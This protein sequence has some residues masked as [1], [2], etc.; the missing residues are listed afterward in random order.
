MR[1]VKFIMKP[2]G[3]P[4]YFSTIYIS[5]NQCYISNLF[6]LGSKRPFKKNYMNAKKIPEE[7]GDLLN[8][9]NIIKLKLCTWFRSILLYPE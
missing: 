2:N 9:R 7:Y 3:I 6:M 8:Q 1:L 5:L 4:I